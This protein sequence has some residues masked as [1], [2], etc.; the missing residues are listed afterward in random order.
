MPNLDRIFSNIRRYVNLDEADQEQMASIIRVN[1]VKKRQFL[2][3]PGFV[4]THQIYVHR[5]ALRSYYVTQLGVEHTIQFALD[6][7]FISDFN[8]YIT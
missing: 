8:S 2:V 3:Q 7:W 6:D 1:N 5:G 4:C